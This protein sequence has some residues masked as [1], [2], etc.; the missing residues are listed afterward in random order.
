[1]IHHSPLPD[2]D[3]PDLS[4]TECVL[5]HAARLATKPALIDGSTGRSLTYGELDH[6]V[7]SFAGGLL[8]RKLSKGDVVAV[9]T[10]NCP[11]FTI[12]LLGTAMAGCVT[13]TINPGYTA[14]EVAHQLDDADA[15]L[16][17]TVPGSVETAREAAVG[18][19]V[20]EIVVIGDDHV[21]GTTPFSALLGVPVDQQQ[22]VDLDDVVVLPYSSGTT[23]LSKG[24]MLTHRNAVANI[25]QAIAT[26]V[27]EG[28]DEVVDAILPFF[29]I[30]GMQVI[31]HTTLA[32]G[33]TVVLLERFDLGQF[34]AMHQRYG[35]TVSFLV[36]PVVLALTNH[37]MVDEYDL[38]ALARVMSAAAPL[39]A[40][41]Q[42]DL[43]DR[44]G[45]EVVQGYGMTELSPVS[46]V[47][48][49]AGVR[50]LA[51]IRS[52]PGSV[53]VL[54]PNTEAMVV[55]PITGEAVG[56]GVHG[57]LWVR[58]PQVMA[59]YLNNPS[60]TAATIDA[61]GWL[62][63]GDLVW[64]DDDGQFYIADRIKELIKYKG[65]QVPPAELEG[66]LLAHPAVADAAVIG[67]PDDHAG[68]VPVAFVVLANGA[69]ATADDIRA[70]VND[71]VA[72]Y[73]RLADVVVIDTIPKSPSGKILRRE[74]HHR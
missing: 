45:T 9:F 38:S 73:K 37:P 56:H 10:P 40:E 60:A 1:M 21:A 70:Y 7:R 50:A 15:C 58:G 30:Y 64:V 46:H 20:K 4:L 5:R 47:V 3:I 33:G 27:V 43:R 2:L 23:G 63:T 29:H 66:L 6:Q 11:E 24:V 26:G 19:R 31:V 12:A 18:T 8:A 72:H 28:E 51:G 14:R 48:P 65:F 35:I 36:P 44:L 25:S 74:L 71:Q 57:E 13:T 52:T 17:V 16:L 54:V 69:I 61:D 34:L 41:Q 62:H 55:D 67:R 42:N 32:L 59:G 39:S 53:G 49:G 68:E 22:S